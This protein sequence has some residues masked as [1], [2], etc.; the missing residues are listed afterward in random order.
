MTPPRRIGELLL[1]WAGWIGAALGWALTHQIG[2]NLDFDHC[3][4]MSPLLAVLLGLAGLGVVIGGGL[5][6]RRAYRRG[7]AG[8]G[9]RHFVAL[10]GM[11]MA[12]LF[13]TALV[14]QT[15]ASLIIPRCY[16]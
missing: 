9:S 8:A 11:L 14:W 5:L 10:L 3:G 1:P 13:S 7:E 12:A 6:S 4:A 16:G 2:S 15:T